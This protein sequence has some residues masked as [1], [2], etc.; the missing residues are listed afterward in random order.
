MKK[1]ERVWARIALLVFAAALV[2]VILGAVFV[3][4]AFL[5][6]ALILIAAAFVISFLKLKCP[7]CGRTTVRPQW[8]GNGTFRCTKCGKPVYYDK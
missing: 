6:P 2:F 7:N 1:L 4:T 8:K 5:Y 3:S